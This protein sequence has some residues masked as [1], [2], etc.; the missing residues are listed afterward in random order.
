MLSSFQSNN[1][2]GNHYPMRSVDSARADI[3]NERKE[4]REYSVYKFCRLEFSGTFLVG[5]IRNIS[6]GGAEIQ[7]RTPPP[8]GTIITYEDGWRD[9]LIG[10]VR[11]VDGDRFGVCNFAAADAD[12]LQSGVLEYPYRSV[13]IA[14]CSNALIW[15]E[16][17]YFPGELRN[18]SRSGAGI[19]CQ[20][21]RRIATGT[22]ASVKVGPAHFRPAIVR[23]HKGCNLGFKFE[24]PMKFQEISQLISAIQE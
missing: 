2:D 20:F 10:E 24:Q 19:A 15:L 22:L 6:S 7:C 9:T 5:I 17:N 1:I 16:H 4:K 14:S 18:I 13:R 21:P 8:V 23:W 12:K 11:W 3:D